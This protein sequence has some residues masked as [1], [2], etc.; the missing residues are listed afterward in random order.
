[1]KCI[2]PIVMAVKKDD[3]EN[4]LADGLTKKAKAAMDKWERIKEDVK[5]LQHPAKWADD[6]G[7]AGPLSMSD[8]V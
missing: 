4:V 7:Y 2:A 3:E 1:V 8:C 5:S 6:D